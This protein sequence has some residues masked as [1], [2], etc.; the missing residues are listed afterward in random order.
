MVA[1]WRC[2]KLSYKALSI[3]LADTP[4][5]EALSLSMVTNV[6]T[7][8]SAWSLSTSINDF[9]AFIAS[10]RRDAHFFR[11]AWLSLLSVYWLLALAE[12][13]PERRSWTGLRN[14]LTPVTLASL[15]RRRAS[16]A[17]PATVRSLA[18]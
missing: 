4:S 13:P 1:T 6:S 3:S 7:P 8:F 16:T 10:A 14:R 5:R 18:G 9:C 15:G 17:L 12:R 2:P 11:S